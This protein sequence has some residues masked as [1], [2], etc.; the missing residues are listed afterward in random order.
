MCSFSDLL[1][2]AHHTDLT[3]IPDPMLL[4]AIEAAQSDSPG[5]HLPTADGPASDRRVDALL[6]AS[7][8]FQPVSFA[9]SCR[10]EFNEGTQELPAPNRVFLGP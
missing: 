8:H 5:E 7:E 3:T 6:E 4:K 1:T 9:M 10:V 2:W